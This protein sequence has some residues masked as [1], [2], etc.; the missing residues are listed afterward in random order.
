M[1]IAYVAEDV[2]KSA[3][4]PRCVAELVERMPPGTEIVVISRC[5]SG[6]SGA[7]IRFYRVPTIGSHF[8]RLITFILGANL[9]LAYLIHVR[10]ERFDVVHS[11]AFDG[12]LFANVVTFHYC[13]REGLLWDRYLPAH[14]GGSWSRWLGTISQLLYHRLLA[15]VERRTLNRPIVAVTVSERARQDFVRHYGA[16]AHRMA[17]IGH[18]VDTWRFHPRNRGLFRKQVRERHGIGEAEVLV[19]FVGDD[20]HRKGLDVLLQA[21]A[22]SVRDWKLLVVGR[23]ELGSHRHEASALGIE[24]R[25]V[26]AGR[27]GAV[28]EYF[29]A[30][31]VFALPTR[32]EP[33]GLVILEAMASGLPVITSACAGAASLVEHGIN[34]YLLETSQDRLELLRC[35]T[36]LADDP[37]LRE[38]IGARARETA[39]CCTWDAAATAHQQLYETLARGRPAASLSEATD[40]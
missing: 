10:K 3:G 18:G 6:V 1:K 20:W 2:H 34:G 40:A 26:F 29:A 33:F 8:L 37:S 14:V 13:A 35:V 17:V 30:A 11:T 28:E 31:D 38:T 7:G 32:Y 21:L 4:V 9:L 16:L 36:A 23:D 15:W 19:L 39:E 25:V 22:A 27:Q 24:H 12:G 5:L